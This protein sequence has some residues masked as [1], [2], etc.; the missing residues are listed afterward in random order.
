MK[1]HWIGILFVLMKKL[2][3]IYICSWKDFNPS[4]T[5]ENLNVFSYVY[6]QCRSNDDDHNI[7]RRRVVRRDDRCTSHLVVRTWNINQSRQSYVFTSQ[8]KSVFS[9]V[10]PVASLLSPAVC[11]PVLQAAPQVGL[12]PLVDGTLQVMA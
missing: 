5:R 2:L 4:G 11:S 7:S 6:I 10:L 9:V 8:V 12:H 3:I 1:I